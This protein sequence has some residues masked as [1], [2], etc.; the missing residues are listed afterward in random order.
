MPWRRPLL[1]FAGAS[2]FGLALAAVA[3]LPFLELL[4]RSADIHQRAGTAQSN[5][6]PLKYALGAFLPD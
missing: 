6:L 2:A 3:V 5:H 1:A 4:S